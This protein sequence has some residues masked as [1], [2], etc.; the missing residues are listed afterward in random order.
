MNHLR[1]NYIVY[2]IQYYVL[3]MYEIY[4]IG[5]ECC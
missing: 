1:E 2:R 4:P 3:Q 5:R